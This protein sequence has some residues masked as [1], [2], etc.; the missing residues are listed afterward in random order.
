M[1]WGIPQDT[2]V[3]K[4]MVGDND[5]SQYALPFRRSA[6]ALRREMMMNLESAPSA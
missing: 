2:L 4:I 3:F 6:W 5:L 1:H